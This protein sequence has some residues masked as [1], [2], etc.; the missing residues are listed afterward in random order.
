MQLC[1]NLKFQGLWFFQS[2]NEGINVG[3]HGPW[4]Q[5]SAAFI[6]IQNPLYIFNN[7]YDYAIKKDLPLSFQMLWGLF[8]YLV[9]QILPEAKDSYLSNALVAKREDDFLNVFYFIFF[10]I[11]ALSWYLPSEVT[12]GK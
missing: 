9:I 6:V 7:A 11:F 4:T 5:V 10:T 12:V 1:E 3:L 8:R 2:R